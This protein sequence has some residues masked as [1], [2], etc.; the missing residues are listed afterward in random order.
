M[1]CF[2]DRQYAEGDGKWADTLF[3]GNGDMWAL[4]TLSNRFVLFFFAW[5]TVAEFF[6]FGHC[7]PYHTTVA[8][9]VF[10]ASLKAMQLVGLL[11][12]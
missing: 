12:S 2:L 9:A 6:F 4:R 3:T 7:S 1:A 5:A 11:P 10:V 8:I